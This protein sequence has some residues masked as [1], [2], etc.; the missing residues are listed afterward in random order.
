MRGR[1]E[2]E[3][4]FLTR[5]AP[6]RRILRK[7]QS[8]G[9]TTAGFPLNTGLHETHEGPPN[10]GGLFFVTEASPLWQDVHHFRQYFSCA[11]IRSRERRTMA[12]ISLREPGDALMSMILTR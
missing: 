2:N 3:I 12:L 9:T 4:G 1:S 5:K 10:L 11:S 8:P 6:V 7:M